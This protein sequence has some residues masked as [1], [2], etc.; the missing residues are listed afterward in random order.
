MDIELGEA[1]KALFINDSNF[2]DIE[3]GVKRI[4]SWQEIF[5]YL[6]EALQ[7]ISWLMLITC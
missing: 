3:R 1:V 2:D 4:R 6:N 7:V 5:G